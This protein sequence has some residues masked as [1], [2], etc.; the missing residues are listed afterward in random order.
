MNVGAINVISAAGVNVSNMNYKFFQHTKC[1]WFPC[2]NILNGKLNCLMCYCPIY[3]YKNCGGEYIILTNGLKDC[4]KC[5]LPHKENGY[6]I[7]IS[8]LIERENVG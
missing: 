6:D 3:H 7:I 1:E 2:K 5:E 8:K 4:S